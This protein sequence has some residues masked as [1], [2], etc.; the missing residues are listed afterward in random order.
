MVKQ[1]SRR[2]PDSVSSVE[3]NRKRSFQRKI[4]AYYRKHGRGL[5]WRTTRDPWHILVSE[6]ML[7]QTQVERVTAKF[8]SFLSTFPTPAA[9]AGAPLNSVLAAWSGLGYNRRALALKKCAQFLC[10]Q[11]QG[12]V[13]STYEDLLELPSIGPYTAAAICVF[14]YNQPRVIL[15][16]NIRSVYLHFFFPCEHRVS[17]HTLQPLVAATLYKKDPRTWYN[18]LMDYGAFLKQQGENPSR[19]SAHYVRQSRF[20]GSDRQIRGIVLRALLEKA[21]Q[22]EAT[23]LEAVGKNP[24]RVRALIQQLIC[25]GFIRKVGTKLSLA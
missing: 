7:Q 15:E 19:R 2:S 13:P 16:T 11:F 4:L 17:D 14:A 18:A 6:V 21:P 10:E 5:P 24:E 12:K 9:L 22:S 23:L 25:E 3:G 8:S 20:Q 1:S